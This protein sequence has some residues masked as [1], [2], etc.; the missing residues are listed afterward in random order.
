MERA[1]RLLAALPRRPGRF[2]LAPA[3]AGGRWLVGF[4]T[5][6][7]VVEHG[8]LE[9]LPALLE[10]GPKGTV[11][12][13]GYELGR[14]LFAGHARED[15]GL[16]R[17]VALRVEEAV[18]IDP[19]TGE[20][21][22][23]TALAALD[24][25][26]R[27]ATSRGVPQ[28]SLD[29]RA[30]RDAVGRIHEAIRAGETY[31]ANLTVRMRAACDGAPEALLAALLAR[32]PQA[33]TAYVDLPGGAAVVS[34]SPESLLHFD[35]ATRRA[36]SLPIKGTRR[37]GADAAE[38]DALAAELAADAKERAEHVMIVDLV[39]NDL[40]RVAEVGSVRVPALFRVDRLPTVLHLVSEVE[41]HLAPA[42]TLPDLVA[43]LFPA[44]SITGAPKLRTL[45]II[46]QLEPVARGPYCGSI[47]LVSPDG[48]CSLSVAIRTAVVQDGAAY[49]GAGGGITID[50]R[51]DAEWEEL[52]LKA[53]PFLAAVGGI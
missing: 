21:S 19:A 52:L 48:S 50:A 49:Y 40:G 35:A 46:D 12:V 29:R 8:G 36:S 9:T 31:Q 15:L 17:A 4:G 27:A 11:V 25:T 33:C 22:G 6:V 42:H 39:R 23:D 20:A 5:P 2:L 3:L 24:A 44:G 13:L 18:A 51:P 53:R 38:D 45:E 7:R 30:H 47:G 37:R 16:P 41:A 1:L 32:G 34:A 26:P 28:F 43:S 14:S 10:P